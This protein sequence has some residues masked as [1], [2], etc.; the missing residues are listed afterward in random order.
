MLKVASILAFERSNPHVQ[1]FLH[2]RPDIE[3]REKAML[4]DSAFERKRIFRTRQILL[5]IMTMI[6]DYAPPGKENNAFTT[7]YTPQAV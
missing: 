2:C 6:K 4:V 1:T 7:N 5:T 3:G